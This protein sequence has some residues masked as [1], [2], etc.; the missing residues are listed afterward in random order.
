METV[1][2]N[3]WI[4]H[5]PFPKQEAALWL[6][7][8][9]EVF[10]GGAA[11]GGKSDWLLMA[12]LQYVDTP[13]YS[14]LLLR[15]SYEDLALPG[16]LLSRAKEWLTGSEAHSPDG[17]RSWLF[18]SGAR[19]VFGYLAHEDDRFRYKSAE[20]QFVGFDELTQFTEPQYTYLFSRLRR[21]AGSEVP[22]RMRSASNPGDVGHE[23]VKR[24]F[25]IGQAPARG[26]GGRR[27][28]VPSTLADNPHLDRQEYESSLAELDP[29]TRA[30]LLGGDWDAYEGG[31]F[32]RS[33]FRRFTDTGD[34]YVLE[35]PH[36]TETFHHA[37]CWR[38][39]TVDPAA[40]EKQTA[41]YTAAGVFAV[42]PNRDLL[43]L[44]VVR[45]HIAVDQIPQRL[46]GL[47]YRY[48][49]SFLGI[50]ASGFQVGIVQA[51]RRR[52]GIP[53]V[54]ELQPQGKDKLV[55]STPAIIR[56]EHGQVFLPHKAPW[57]GDFEA[58]LV[59]FTGDEKKDAHDDQV[60]VLAYAVLAL[61][62]GGL[63]RPKAVKDTER[64]PRHQRPSAAERRGL[65]G[66]AS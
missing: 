49:P 15:R 28:F 44:D 4:P 11:G 3:P 29:V 1:L 45:E 19:I 41:D 8:V 32:Q 46:A 62:R 48:D 65:Y 51:C 26:P 42:T 40:S 18:P 5:R 24:R 17:G 66:R 27:V 21:L 63:V 54:R 30:Q 12:A 14:A 22:I 57:L 2:R 50:E 10:Y 6:S 43:V 31:R 61:D 55:R 59:Q 33:W 34:R 16:A 64:L 23:W 60:D 56:C 20:F 47:C 25:G 38:F 58:E 9:P 52:P 35:H 39:M 7:D 13:G 37:H 53:T 36:G